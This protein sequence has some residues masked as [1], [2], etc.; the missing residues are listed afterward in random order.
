MEQFATLA[1]D[2]AQQDQRTRQPVLLL[3]VHLGER[4]H[5][6]FGGIQV[7]ELVITLRQQELSLCPLV[8]TYLGCERL[9]V[10]LGIAPLVHR[11]IRFGTSV[12][13]LLAGLLVQRRVAQDL[14]GDIDCCLMT[15]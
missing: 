9:Q 10:R 14:L 12:E 15:T 3:R 5:F 7:L 6:G 11:H 8:R 1:V 13:R 4:H 2:I